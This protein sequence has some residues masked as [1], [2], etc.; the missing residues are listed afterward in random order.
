MPLAKFPPEVERIFAA[1]GSMG[2]L[3]RE[4]DWAS[5]PIGAPDS[6]PQSLRTAV[7][8]C[9]ESSFPML[10]WWGPDFVKLYNDAYSS[11]I[12]N[13][14]PQAMGQRGEDCWPEIWDEIG[15]MLTDVKAGRG[16]TFSEDQVMRL[17]RHGFL[18][19]CYF[20][21]SFSPIRDESGGIGGVFTAA[22]ESTGRILGARRLGTLRAQLLE[23]GVARPAEGRLCLRSGARADPGAA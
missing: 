16:A 2:A 20:T 9:L 23:L 7:S 22:T 17:V 13:K 18:E 4:V 3:M 11:L 15:P 5:T 14:H 10:V 21:F 12:G 6:W 19:E 8:V 1:G